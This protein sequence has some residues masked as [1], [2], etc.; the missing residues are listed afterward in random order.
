MKRKLK[1]GVVG[2]TGMV[3]QTFMTLLAEREFPIAELRPFASE[4]SL[5]KKIELQ[6][7]QWPCQILKEGC[8]EGL[9]LVFFSSGDDISAEW[10][11][12]AVKAGAFAVDNSAAFRMDPNTVLIVP[13]VNGHLLN[14]D[15][16]PQVIANPNCSTIQL[17]VALKPLSEKFGL[18]EVRVSTYQAVSGAGQ[19]GY[20]ELMEQTSKATQAQHEPKTFP[21]TILF[22]CIPQIGSFNDDG[23]CSEEVK[24]MKET[25]KILGLPQLKVSAFT[26]RIPALNAHSESVWVTLKK[27]TTREA[28]T[29]ALASHEGIVVQDDPKRSVYPLA[30]EVSGK[31]P[32]YVGRIHRDPE[33]SKLWMM[34]VVSDNIRKGAALNGIQIA[35]QIFF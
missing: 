33:D 12:K 18:D 23:F 29:D 34:W 25:R 28:I 19:G 11:P 27:D 30:R 21:H 32:V 2:A 26:V 13:E 6:G 8:F 16:K 14:K 9:D 10:A 3:G 35:E 20:D 17:V 5:G 22:N 15:S 4:N 24:I 7:Q 31:D 1:V